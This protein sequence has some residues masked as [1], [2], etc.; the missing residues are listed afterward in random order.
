MHKSQ[1]AILW[2]KE[3]MTKRQLAD[4]LRIWQDLQ[5]I[6]MNP[7]T[8]AYHP[9]NIH[10]IQTCIK[11]AVLKHKRAQGKPIVDDRC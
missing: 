5:W 3:D 4:A 1:S 8:G 6:M 2:L 10:G 11:K 9:S 7:E